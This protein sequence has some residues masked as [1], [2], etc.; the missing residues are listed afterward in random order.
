MCGREYHYAK[1]THPCKSWQW[2][3]NRYWGKLNLKRNDHWVF[4]DKATGRYLLKF[5]WFP[6]E[7]H[8]LVKGSASPD[9]ARLSA[10]WVNRRKARTGSLASQA[11]RIA[12][13]QGYAC[14]HCREELFNGEELHL[15]HIVPRA[16]GGTNRDENLRLIHL[17][18]HQQIHRTTRTEIL[19]L[20]QTRVAV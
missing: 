7:R 19:Q 14:A 2:R 20:K 8:V 12:R 5:A 4:G 18:C 1:F 17:Y 15:D 10:Y 13:R 6:I 9:D 11:Q 3:Q 16:Q